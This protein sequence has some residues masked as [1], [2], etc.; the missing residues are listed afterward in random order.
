MRSV[1]QL[2]QSKRGTSTL[3]LF[4]GGA[5][6]GSGSVFTTLGKVLALERRCRAM[7][8][9]DGSDGDVVVKSVCKEVEQ[10]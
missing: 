9:I 7:V 6:G 10:I 8:E 1:L 3:V 2:V 4:L 5:V